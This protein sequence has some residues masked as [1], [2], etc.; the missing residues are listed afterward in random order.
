MAQ[1][2]V[3]LDGELSLDIPL[4]GDAQLDLQLDGAVG[5]LT[6]IEAGI[7]QIIFNDDYTITFVLTDG[8]RFTTGS[9]R[10]TVGEKG[11]KGDKGDTGERGE[12]GEQ[13]E[14]GPQG[15]TGAQ[16][17]QGERGE[18][19]IQGIQGVKGDT[20]EKGDKGDAFTYSDFTPEQLAS[21]KGEKGDK[22]DAAITVDAVPTQGST[23]AV[24]S[25]GVFSALAEKPDKDSTPET[26]TP[27]ETDADFYLSDA[28]GNVLLELADGHIKT[29]EF[30]SSNINTETDTTLRV[31]GKPADAKAVGDAISAVEDDI[32]AVEESIP[33]ISKLPEGKLTAAQNV[34]LDITDT[35]GNVILRLADGHIR[36]KNFDSSRS[37]QNAVL[38]VNNTAPDANGNVNVRAELDPEEIQPAVDDYLDNHPVVASGGGVVSVADYGA[39]GDGVTDDSHAIQEAVNSNYDVYFESDRTYYLASEVTIKHDAYLHGGKN[40]VIKTVTPS[41]AIVNNG[42]NASGTLKYTTTLTT[43]Y[44]SESNG[45]S[46]NM[47]NRLT[48]ADMSNVEIGDILVIKATDQYYSPTRRYYYL[49]ATLLVTDIYE[50]HIYVHRNMP[51]DIT[52]TNRVTVAVYSAPTIRI[53]NLNFVS[54]TNAFGSEHPDGYTALVQLSYCKNSTVTDCDFDHFKMGLKANNCVNTEFCN[55]TLAKSRYENTSGFGDG[56]AIAVYSSTHTTVRR[57]ISLCAQNSIDF[58]GDVPCIDNYILQCDVGAECRPNG[59]GLHENSY[60]TVI[61]DCILSGCTLQGTVTLNRCQFVRN[62]RTNGYGS[63]SYY[64]LP[65]PKHARLRVSNCKFPI[66][67]ASSIYIQ[68]QGYQDYVSSYDE[69]IDSVIIENCIGGS[70]TYN[71]DIDSVVKSHTVNRM[72]IDNWKDC[73]EFY[74]TGEGLIKNLDIK[75]STFLRPYAINKHTD[76]FYTDLI[77]NTFIHSDLPYKK[78]LH[79]NLKD[80][81]GARYTLPEKTKINVS[82]DDANAEFLVCGTNCASDSYEDYA[83]GAISAPVDGVLSMTPDATATGFLTSSDRKLIYTIPAG[84]TTTRHIYPKGLLY[85]EEDEFMVFTI[86]AILKNTGGTSPCAFRPYIVLVD[87]KTDKVVYSGN[88]TYKEASADGTVVTHSR[89]CPKGC[90]AFWYL[91]NNVAVDGSETSIE[92]IT[93]TLTRYSQNPPEYT[94]YTGNKISGSGI[95][96]SVSGQNNIICTSGTFDVDFMADYAN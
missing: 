44:I 84:Y 16:G 74:L 79:V 4:D 22:G 13:G 88:G 10:G 41:D 91:Q 92:Q 78:E 2:E 15:E 38:T 93:A 87:T 27:E 1:D 66:N 30:D 63:L 51:F 43:D 82:S 96:E 39:V 19:G 89:R 65:N 62:A 54:D 24:S 60:N 18:Q 32:Q 35:N 23:N 37:D 83:V 76:A 31:Q 52:L 85:A 55:I 36:T 59:I 21:L 57:V 90:A 42:F 72:I 26:V 12:K 5:L 58:S 61:E 9:I 34:D 45:D 40:T 70:L 46:D 95:I 69:V 33:D 17:I 94:E 20:G 64:G 49:G 86:S 67:A 6:L 50:G 29:K 11:D 73:Y 25:G 80:A 75:D 68:E 8:R 56:Y 28:N 14:R 81:Y 53:S 7:A 48:L 77:Q 71:A 3:I 47:S